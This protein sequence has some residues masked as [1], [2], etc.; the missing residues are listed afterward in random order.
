MAE[1]SQSYGSYVYGK[2]QR[3]RLAVVA[4]VSTRYAGLLASSCSTPYSIS[5]RRLQNVHPECPRGCTLHKAIS[6]RGSRGGNRARD[7]IATPNPI[8]RFFPVSRLIFEDTARD[9]TDS[10]LWW[11]QTPNVVLDAYFVAKGRTS[12][13]PLQIV[14]LEHGRRRARECREGHVHPKRPRFCTSSSFS[15]T[16]E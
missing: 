10:N 5:R 6:I 13:G 14:C 15:G 2:E 8:G 12:S 4:V 16:E 9:N 3:T 1:A 11:R 7:P